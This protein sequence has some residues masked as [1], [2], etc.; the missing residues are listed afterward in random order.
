MCGGAALVHV[1]FHAGDTLDDRAARAG[2]IEMNVREQDG[3]D[4]AQR[5]AAL[6][7]PAFERGQTRRRTRIDQRD[8]V[9]AL[10]DRGARSRAGCR[11]T[12][13]RCSRTFNRGTTASS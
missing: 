6:A 7:Q 1:D 10:Q 9:G 8:A 11:E 4:V 5:E 12:A 2:V 3:A 13:D